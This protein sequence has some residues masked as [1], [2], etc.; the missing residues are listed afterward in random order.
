MSDPSRS[1]SNDDAGTSTQCGILNL[2]NE[3]DFDVAVIESTLIVEELDQPR[4]RLVRKAL[5]VFNIIIEDNHQIR[6]LVRYID[7]FDEFD[8]KVTRNNIWNISYLSSGNREEDCAA[9]KEAVQQ[10]VNRQATITNEQTQAVLSVKSEDAE[11]P[12]VRSVASSS[13]TNRRSYQSRSIGDSNFRLANSSLSTLSENPGISLIDLAKRQNRLPIQN[14]VRS[15]ETTSIQDFQFIKVLG[16]GCMGKV[17]LVRERKNGKLLALKAISKEWAVM[18]REIEHTKSERDILAAIAEISHPFLIKLHHS[19]QDAEQLFLVLDFYVGGDI[20]TQLA[21]HYHFDPER[22]RLYIAEILLGLQELHRVGVLYRDLKPENILIAADGHIVLTDFGLSK[23]FAPSIVGDDQRTNTFCGTAEYLAPEIL[24]AEPYSFEVD[25]WS[26]GTLLY[27]FL[28]GITPFWAETHTEMYRRVLEDTLV[29]PEDFDPV[30]ADFIDGL[31]QRDPSMRLGAGIDGP[32]Q[33][34]SHPYFDGLDWDDVFHKRITPRY[35][36][37]LKSDMDFS[38]FDDSFLQMVPRISNPPGKIILTSDI[39]DIF[40]GY[41]YTESV[42][43]SDRLTISTDTEDHHFKVYAGHEQHSVGEPSENYLFDAVD[44]DSAISGKHTSQV[45]WSSDMVDHTMPTIDSSDDDLQRY[46]LMS[47]TSA[48]KRAN[49]SSRN[50]LRSLSSQSQIIYPDNGSN[51]S[52]GGYSDQERK[53]F[54]KRRNTIDTDPAAEDIVEPQGFSH[55][56]LPSTQGTSVFSSMHKIDKNGNPNFSIDRQLQIAGEV[57]AEPVI[58]SSDDD[59]I[60]A[61]PQSAIGECLSS[62]IVATLV[63]DFDSDKHLDLELPIY[64]V[65][66][67]N[68]KSD[69]N[70]L[71]ASPPSSNIRFSSISATFPVFRRKSKKLQGYQ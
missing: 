43:D 4:R 21:K 56:T 31:L 27:E 15:K 7:D 59:S 30:T 6:S 48:K 44:T 1:G 69:A 71:P 54:T 63:P 37:D 3:N 47:H 35:I 51:S 41:S 26:M 53:R 64:K 8:Q 61:S 10:F 36:P 22:C 19:F 9:A 2:E 46:G 67:I 18:Q 55:P 65:V 25:F 50:D 49:E 62:G 52:F 34:C 32:E 5:S 20:A 14:H 70:D 28:T 68:S 23:Q 33:I 40:D 57:D 13:N 38:N 12:D 58:E 17:I 11:V 24:R 29:F 42:V 16:K 39:Q 66:D 45:I 60:G